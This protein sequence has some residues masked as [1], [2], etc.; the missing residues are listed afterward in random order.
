RAVCR[1]RLRDGEGRVRGD[2]GGGVGEVAHDVE[3]A[4]V[5]L[6][7]GA[8]RKAFDP[9]VAALPDLHAFDAWRFGA[10]G[11]GGGS[12][13]QLRWGEDGGGGDGGDGPGGGGRHRS[14][15]WSGT[16][17]QAGTGHPG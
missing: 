8:D 7:V 17:R 14:R 6:A 9:T 12:G 3:A 13:G 15:G 16:S 4:D 5:G 2:A 11:V 1:E 10:G